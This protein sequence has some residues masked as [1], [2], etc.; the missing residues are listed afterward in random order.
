[1]RALLGFEP[2][3]QRID[4]RVVQIVEPRALAQRDLAERKQRMTFAQ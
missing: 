1:M 4:D 2:N 3:A